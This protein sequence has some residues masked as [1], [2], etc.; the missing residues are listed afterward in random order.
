VDAVGEDV[1]THTHV[2]ASSLVVPAGQLPAQLMAVLAQ[3]VAEEPDYKARTAAL[4]LV[5]VH[6][7]A[8]SLQQ[9][10]RALCV[11]AA[12]SYQRRAPPPRS[13]V[14]VFLPTANLTALFAEAAAGAG[15]RGV[16]EIHSRKSQTQRDR[17]SA[18]F[19]GESRLVLFSS[20]VSARGVD[21]PNVTLVVQ[22]GAAWGLLWESAPT[23]LPER[24]A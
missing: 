9:C 5:F 17:A 12:G 4:G 16:V 2:E 18:Q 6:W 24:R 11:R 22:V 1:A 13:Q 15:L 21:Y 20:D 10:L 14:I 3:H 8:F 19:R 7:A 23:V